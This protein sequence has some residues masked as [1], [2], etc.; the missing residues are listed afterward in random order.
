MKTTI[1]LQFTDLM[2]LAKYIKV[3][4]ASTYRIDT[5]KLTVKTSLTEFE[6]AIAIEQYRAAVVEQT[7]IA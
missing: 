4:H 5:S 7:E 2:D 3:I 6:L 1:T